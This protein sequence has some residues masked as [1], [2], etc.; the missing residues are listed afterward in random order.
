MKEKFDLSLILACYN[1]GTIFKDNVKK[2][3]NV[4]D[5]TDFSYEIIFI[6]DASIDKTGTA[7]AKIIKDNPL[8]NLRSIYHDKNQGRGKT[9]TEGIREAKG[10]VVGF[11]DIDLEIPADYLPRFV[12]AILSG[13]DVAIAYR[14]YD[15][16]LRRLI[17][18]FTSKGYIALRKKLLKT[19]LKD[20]E[21][22]YK[23]FNRQK[24]LPILK[25][26]KDPGWFWDTEIMI[27]SSLNNLRI[28]EIP[29][30]FIR[31]FQK[32]STVKLIPDTF[33]YLLKI[34]K[35]W[36]QLKNNQMNK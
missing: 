12:N 31:N 36:Q 25:K 24:I 22:G 10:K 32:K 2:V 20:T 19:D 5:Q 18:W 35:F 34:I 26:T 17:R 29:T 27:N 3:F 9:V 16:T 8:R 14:V 4:L 28:M 13:Y 23:F 1:E 11:I 6:D 21:A 33:D 30:V 7:I 15:F